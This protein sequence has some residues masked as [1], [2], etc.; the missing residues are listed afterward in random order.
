ML[1]VTVTGVPAAAD[2]MLVG[3]VVTVYPEFC[4]FAALRMFEMVV[5]TS[6]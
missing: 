2:V 1:I 6:D 3:L 4:R 5:V